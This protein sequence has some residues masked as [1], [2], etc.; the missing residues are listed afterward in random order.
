MHQKRIV[1][2]IPIL[3]LVLLIPA[4]TSSHAVSIGERA[5]QNVLD[6]GN[7]NGIQAVN[8]IIK[9]IAELEAIDARTLQQ[10][11]ELNQYRLMLEWFASAGDRFRQQELKELILAHHDPDSYKQ[12]VDA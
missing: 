6:D 12:A 4:E 10:D 3:A 1:Y 11:F 2:M 5:L 8:E 9:R 7:E